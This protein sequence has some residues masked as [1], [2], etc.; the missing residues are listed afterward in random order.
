MSTQPV[1]VDVLSQQI[2]GLRQRFPEAHIEPTSEG[3]R[4]LVV[5]GVVLPS[6]WNR[7]AV[8]LRVQI[9]TG[10]PHV[11]PDC[12]YTDPDLRLSN[13]ST[14]MNGGMQTV[15]GAQYWWFSWHINTWDPSSGSLDQFVRVC[16]RR[17]KDL[18]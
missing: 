14:P 7:K 1:V 17:L 11:K 8:T 16:E 4:V 9:P 12:F 2:A 10:Y 18:R 6:G 5:P 3:L 13:G 15:F